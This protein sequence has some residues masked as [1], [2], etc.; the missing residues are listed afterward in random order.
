MAGSRDINLFGASLAGQA[1]WAALR[2]LDPRVLIA[3]PVML[4]IEVAAALPTF[5]LVWALLL[6]DSSLVA[7]TGQV[8]AWC[9]LTVFLASFAEAMAEARRQAAP[10]RS[11]RYG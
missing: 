11:V 7:F 6:A 5:L 9:W 10:G 2:G 3:N 1:A 8:A 4:V